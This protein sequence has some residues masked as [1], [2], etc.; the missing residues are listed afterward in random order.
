MRRLGIISLTLWIILTVIVIT[1]LVD[2]EL[3]PGRKSISNIDLINYGKI[4]IVMIG[5]FIGTRFI[6]KDE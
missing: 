3:N 6:R 1:F 5:I 4:S 2:R